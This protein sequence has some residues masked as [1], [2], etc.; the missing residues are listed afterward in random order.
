M[1]ETEIG[2][3]NKSETQPNIRNGQDSNQMAEKR[4]Q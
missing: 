4:T 3:V 1:S 2:N